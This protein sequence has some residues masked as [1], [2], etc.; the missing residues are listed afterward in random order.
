M[1]NP[2]NT[3]VGNKNYGN[4][5]EMTF[6]QLDALGKQVIAENRGNAALGLP[7]GLGSSAMGKYQMIDPTR[8][9]LAE[10]R[11]G[12]DY[13]NVVYSPE[14]QEQLAEDLYNSV[15]GDYGKIK[16]Q[17]VGAGKSKELEANPSMPWQEARRHISRYES[18]DSDEGWKTTAPNTVMAV[19]NQPNTAPVLSEEAIAKA[20]M[21]MPEGLAKNESEAAMAR[22]KDALFTDLAA[23][24]AARESAA[25]K[26]AYDM[27]RLSAEKEEPMFTSM[28]VPEMKIPAMTNVFDYKASKASKQP[29]YNFNLG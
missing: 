29:K 16:G 6:G 18:A 21:L 12:K 11:F 17:W 20:R 8:N 13:K 4:I 7:P 19:V 10:K 22:T 9:T 23:N 1:S 25:A 27:G 3:V 24:A 14:V 28:K 15:K 2:Y 26:H 5:S